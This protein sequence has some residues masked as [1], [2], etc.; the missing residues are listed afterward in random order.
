MSF[1]LARARVNKGHSIRGLAR[2]VGVSE[3]TLRRLE[4]GEVVRP[5]S[6]KPV[7]DFFKVQVTDL[8]PADPDS[9]A[10]A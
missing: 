9:K 5:E 6:A 1:D 7:A 3:P 4:R 10:A 8:M 2:E